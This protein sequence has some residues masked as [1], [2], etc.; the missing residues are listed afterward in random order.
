MEF[1]TTIFG[2][3]AKKTR[4]GATQILF[5]A[6]RTWDG[7][8]TPLPI[9]MSGGNFGV[10]VTPLTPPTL[11][12][13]CE[14]TLDPLFYGPSYQPGEGGFGFDQIAKTKGKEIFRPSR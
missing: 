2:A 9:G 4:S 10:A 14:G 13:G 8:Y 11:Y 3:Y 1:A 5:Q 6:P 12:L 7:N